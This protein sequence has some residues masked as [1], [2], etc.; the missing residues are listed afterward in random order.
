MAI[1]APARRTAEKPDPAA[2]NPDLEVDDE[3]H[4]DAGDIAEEPPSSNLV[5]VA[6]TAMTILGCLLL[7]FVVQLVLL[8]DL[9][10]NR[11]Q[12]VSYANFRSELALGTAPVSALDSNSKP[13]KIGA[14]VAVLEIPLLHMREVVGQGTT[15]SVLADGPGHRRD[16]VLPG[17]AGVSIIM[18]RRA[19]YGAP[20]N[21]LSSLRVGDRINVTTGQGVQHFGVI[22]VRRAGDPSP[23][24]AAA[25]ESRLILMTATGAAYVPDGVLR[26]DAKLISTVQPAG[27]VGLSAAQLPTDEKPLQGEPGAWLPIVLWGQVLLAAA[28]AFAWARSRW[29][30]WQAWLVGV[31]ILTAVGLEVASSFIRLL[32]NLL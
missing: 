24:A 9:E 2:D 15:S 6:S 21:R 27:L 18:G 11:A 17:Q 7:G 5:M 20:F 31:P 32:P 1:F 26:V 13:V 28:L 4:D 19:A 30:F 10:H 23:A 29:G 12:R 8:S 16:T 3:V 22:D 25:D 14:A